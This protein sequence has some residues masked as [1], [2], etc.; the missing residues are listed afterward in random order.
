MLLTHLIL[1]TTTLGY[2][3]W[4]AKSKLTGEKMPSFE[5]EPKKI[6][7]NSLVHGRGLGVLGDYMF[8]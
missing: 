4:W 7:T 2:V 8:R 3:S 6:I 5:K 1:A